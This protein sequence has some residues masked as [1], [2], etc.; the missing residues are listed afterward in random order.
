MTK[1]V[2]PAMQALERRHDERLGLASSAD[3]GSSRIRIGA[4]RRIARAIVMR[5]CSP[6]ESVAPP[7]PTTVSSPAGRRSMKSSS[8][9]R[10][11]AARSPPASRR[12]GRRRCS[13]AASSGRRAAAGGP[14]RPAGAAPQLELAH[15]DAVEQ[16]AARGRIVEARASG[17]R[18]SSCRRRSAP[19]IATSR[20]P[21]RR[22]S[23]PRRTGPPGS[24]RSRRPRRLDRA[25]HVRRGEA[26]VAV[27]QVGR[28]LEDL[29][30]PLGADP[31]AL[32]EA[33]RLR[34]A[35]DRR[36]ERRQVAR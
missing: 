9:A 8:C 26:A 17:S 13:R 20:R 15:V 30:H 4:S 14:S 22:S 5:S 10:R 1:V 19:T 32:D 34:Q 6:A 27:G 12:A 23:T 35:V 31:R 25:V 11:A 7:S 36:V 2:R 29:E 28:R 18:A 24:Y 21:G 33:A 3:V 16:H